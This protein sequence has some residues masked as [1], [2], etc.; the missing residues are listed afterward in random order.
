MQDKSASAPK[1]HSHIAY[2]S[3]REKGCRPALDSWPAL[4][5]YWVALTS[6]LICLLTT[7]RH[8]MVAQRRG[9]LLMG[10][11]CSPTDGG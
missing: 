2:Q 10:E 6:A 9:S 5:G 1:W 3:S 4:F 7:V 8:D 11:H